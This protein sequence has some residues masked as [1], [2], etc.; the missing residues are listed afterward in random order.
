MVA[1]FPIIEHIYHNIVIVRAGRSRLI[2]VIYHNVALIGVQS[3]IR[4]RLS[5]VPELNFYLPSAFTEFLFLSLELTISS[6][7]P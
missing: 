7:T 3:R 4:F 6:P 1:S 2:C 5:L